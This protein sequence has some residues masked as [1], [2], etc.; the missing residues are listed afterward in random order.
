LKLAKSTQKS[1]IGECEEEARKRVRE[2]CPN[3]K[4][5]REKINPTNYRGWSSSK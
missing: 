1:Y 2:S 3:P 4:R 5:V